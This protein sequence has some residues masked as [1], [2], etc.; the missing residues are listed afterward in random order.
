VLAPF[1]DTRPTTLA[2]AAALLAWSVADFVL[3][4]HRPRIR[5]PVDWTV[6]VTICLTARSTTSVDQMANGVSWVVVVAAIICL[7]LQ[8]YT[9][10]AVGITLAA[11]IAGAF[12]LGG[13]LAA[14][15]ATVEL[16]PQAFLFL[17]QTSLCRWLYRMLQRGAH[18][19]DELELRMAAQRQ[20][21][22]V[23]AAQRADKREYLAA[24]HDTAAST[25]LM[26]G[27]GLAG[28]EP[29]IQRQAAAD[30][31]VIRG[32]GWFDTD[33]EVDLVPVL[34]GLCGDARFSGPRGPVL[35]PTRQAGAIQGAVTEAL[36]N[37]RRHAGD[38]VAEVTLS[39]DD[40]IIVTVKDE[41]VGFDP[42]SIPVLHRGIQD[43]I[44]ARMA[45]AGGHADV[46]SAPG[47][48]TTV[49]LKL[50][51]GAD[52]PAA[53]PRIEAPEMFSGLR[54]AIAVITLAVVFGEYLPTLIA[55]AA[56]YRSLPAQVIA[57]VVIAAVVSVAAARVDHGFARTPVILLTIVLAMAAV[58]MAAQD[59]T[60]LVARPNWAYPLVGMVGVLL[61]MDRGVGPL[62]GFL[63]AHNVITA[64]VVIFNGQSWSALVSLGTLASIVV[65]IEFAIG[66]VAVVLRGV[67]KRAGAIV[68]EQEQLRVH[69]AIQTQLQRDR[70][71]RYANVA[72]TAGPVLAGLSDGR[73]DPSDE[74][75]R[76]T[77][78]VEAARMRR[79]FAENDESD[80]PLLH[81][82]RACAD[83]AERN[84]V[85]VALEASGSGTML[86]LVKR[87]LLT[88]PVL[89]VLAVATESARITVTDHDSSVTVS[90]V[91]DVPGDASM[92]GPSA[93][94]Q[95][96]C[97]RR[98]SL[99]WLEVTLTRQ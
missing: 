82:L 47:H 15:D 49:V 13:W 52:E 45:V 33:H 42:S 6:A 77:C 41:G 11:G 97:V 79:L 25:L 19:A 46:R 70:E 96:D 57:F 21:A 87:R 72:S 35:V 85:Q 3:L 12:V 26:V 64:A 10:T 27:M 44:M 76:R 88:D 99:A 98:G 36:G 16:L 30:L 71:A 73:L 59:P 81:E 37:V 4:R 22:A 29:W 53:A 74:S 34:T 86:P 78:A 50:P 93:G 92:P 83:L 60:D 90:V 23:E 61:L 31:H 24:L 51:V 1:V 75:V 56:T 54:R 91:A 28:R 66:A 43:S 40:G 7:S 32:G 80:A 94:I 67:T 62:A 17:A 8:L 38:V 95:L 58:S 63:V 14:P 68:H 69:E 9:T 65:G 48:G 18:V 84:G 89:A 39:V 55:H 20:A 2:I 5:L